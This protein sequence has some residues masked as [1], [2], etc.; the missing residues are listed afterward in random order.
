MVGTGVAVGGMVGVAVGNA[1]A[2]GAGVAVEVGVAVAEGVAVDGMGVAM[3]AG[4]AAGGVGA[5]EDRVHRK[6]ASA[7]PK[8]ASVIAA[9]AR[10]IHR[11]KEGGV[12]VVDFIPRI[13]H[14]GGKK[15]E[16]G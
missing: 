8:L 6:K 13:I 1:V 9:Q 14:A 5:T 10:C 2:V 15:G 3:G 7:K 11:L 12:A 16:E 4:V